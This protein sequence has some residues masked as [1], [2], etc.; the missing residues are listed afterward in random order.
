MIVIM[1]LTWSMVMIWIHAS[2][3]LE[4]LSKVVLLRSSGIPHIVIQ[5]FQRKWFENG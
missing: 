4:F 3:L 2:S 1:L 5:L